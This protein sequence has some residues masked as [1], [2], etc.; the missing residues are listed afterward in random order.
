M[1]KDSC[2]KEERKADGYFATHSEFDVKHREAALDEGLCESFPA[3]DPVAVNISRVVVYKSINCLD[4]LP[5]SA[6]TRRS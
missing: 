6:T 3:S 4:Q 5:I 1:L 2:A